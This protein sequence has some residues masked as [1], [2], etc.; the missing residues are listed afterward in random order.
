MQNLDPELNIEI[1]SI[2]NAALIFRAINNKLRQKIIQII[3]E[4]KSLTVTQIYKQLKLEQSVAS[5]HLSILRNAKMVK[6]FRDGKS[7]YYSINYKRFYQINEKSQ[8][9]VKG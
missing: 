6:A 2:K 4:N 8:V 5:Q 3:H 1:N 7:V 9:I